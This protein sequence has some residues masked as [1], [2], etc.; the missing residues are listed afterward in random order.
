VTD[1]SS[2]LGAEAVQQLRELDETI[3]LRVVK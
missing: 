2:G 1:I 3:L